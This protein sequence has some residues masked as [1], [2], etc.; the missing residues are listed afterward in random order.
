M[1]AQ[2]RRARAAV[3]GLAFVMASLLAAP[4]GAQSTPPQSRGPGLNLVRDAEIEQLIRDYTA[5]ILKAAGLTKGSVEVLLVNESTYNAFVVSGTRMFIHTGLLM[6]AETPNEVIGVIAHETGH[7]AGNHLIRLRE[8]LARAQTMAGIAAVIGAGIVVAGATTNTPSAAQAGAAAGMAG[9][10]VAQRTLLAYARTEEMTADRM[11]ITFLERTGQSGAGMLKSFKRFAD[12]VL[13]SARYTDPYVQTHPMPRERI[14]QLEQLIT[15]SK[16]AN[17][18][19]P[20]AMVARH[21]M[22]RAKLSGFTETA[23]RIQRRY[24]AAD[25]S[26][27]AR[28]ARAIAAFRFGRPA[29]AVR[30]IDGL[31]AEQPGNPFFH[32]LKGQALLESGKAREAIAPLRR[33][34]GLAPNQPLLRAMLG[35]ALLET[36]D[37]GLLDEAIKELTV[38]VARE[39]IGA[40]PAYRHLATAH[41][42]K[43]D[44]ATADLMIAQ[45]FF[46]E[47][48]IDQAKGHAK[49]AQAQLKVGSP[50]WVK[51]DDI[52]SFKQPKL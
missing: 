3:T 32:E 5:P 1:A 38:G 46:A 21:A 31:I 12:Q 7:I 43:G 28:Y 25:T 15:A 8:A 16:F 22:A 20:P 35:H 40:G 10:H 44:Q 23:N 42:R 30:S 13:L 50:G 24:P 41:A 29:D 9:A 51:A 47:G 52:L 34:V 36:N 4:V 26:L 33:A 48:Q 19:D 45:G 18:A 27:P 2:V 11:A 17:A 39:T 6:E 37:P 49:R 14:S